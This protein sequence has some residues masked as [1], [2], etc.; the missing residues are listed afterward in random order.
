MLLHGGIGHRLNALSH[1]GAAAAAA[2]G[3]GGG[4][5][6]FVVVVVVAVLNAMMQRNCM[7]S[8]D[9]QTCVTFI[10][11]FTVHGLLVY[12]PTVRCTACNSVTAL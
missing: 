8:I 7:T 9:D 6:V 2:G 1:A 11:S 5:V 12:A 4:L 3:V 10:W